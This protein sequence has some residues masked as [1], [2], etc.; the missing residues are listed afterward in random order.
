MSSRLGSVGLSPYIEDDE[1]YT[2][3]PGGD[4]QVQGA[5]GVGGV[6]REGIVN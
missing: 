2:R 4:Q 3:V 1:A 5:G 6:G